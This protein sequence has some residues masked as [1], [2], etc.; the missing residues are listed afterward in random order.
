MTALRQSA[1]HGSKQ[2][3]QAHR[4]A[5]GCN[6]SLGK[7]AAPIP[8]QRE[9]Q[10]SVQLDA[11]SMSIAW[12]S[13]ESS[14]ASIF[15]CKIGSTNAAHSQGDMLR[16]SSRCRLSKCTGRLVCAMWQNSQVSPLSHEPMAKYRQGLLQSSGCPTLPWLQIGDSNMG[17][18]KA[19]GESADASAPIIPTR[20][21]ST[22]K[23]SALKA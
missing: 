21:E 9:S 10:M 1:L 13:S 3:P 19:C 7:V 8:F 20:A 22:P 12:V 18:A 5:T 6:T 14:K 23:A 15:F 2:G 4:P 11:M 17:A 16:S